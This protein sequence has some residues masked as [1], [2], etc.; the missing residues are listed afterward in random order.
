VRPAGPVAAYPESRRCPESL[1]LATKPQA[2]T[3]EGHRSAW[4]PLPC[5]GMKLPAVHYAQTNCPW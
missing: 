2:G 5:T 4:A 1:S 3:E